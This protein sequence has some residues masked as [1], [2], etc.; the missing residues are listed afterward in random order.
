MSWKGKGKE[1]KERRQQRAFKRVRE[2]DRSD[3]GAD[4]RAIP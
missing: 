1:V 3:K 4:A 2:G